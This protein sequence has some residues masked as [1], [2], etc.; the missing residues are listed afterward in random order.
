[1][2]LVLISD[3]H[4]Q[5]ERLEI[6]DGDVLIHAG[7]LTTHGQISELPAFNDFLRGLPHRH[8]LVVAGNHDFC[9]EEQ[10]QACAEILNQAIYLQD[11]AVTLDGVRYYGSPWQPRFFDWAFNLDRGAPLRAKWDL[12]P[13]DT[14]VL[15][16]HGPPWG[17]GDL[18]SEGERVGCRDLWEVVQRVRPRLHIFGHIHEG[19]GLTRTALITFANASNCNLRYRPVNPPLVFDYPRSGSTAP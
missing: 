12:I 2:R 8:K 10:P 17:H 16:T 13:P 15:I 11:E 3:T 4:G 5:H 18:N 7:D 14:D 9:F 1:M 19:Y 6:P